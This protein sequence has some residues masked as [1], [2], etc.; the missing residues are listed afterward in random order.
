MEAPVDLPASMAPT[1]CRR[2]AGYRLD[3][4]AQRMHPEFLMQFSEAM[5][6]GAGDLLITPQTY[7]S[8]II[9]SHHLI[10]DS[11]CAVGRVRADAALLSD[12][13]TAGAGAIYLTTWRRTK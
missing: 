12:A 10:N 13:A 5:E 8:A 6:I 3:V 4:R 1:D 11:V 2:Q 9:L 7:P